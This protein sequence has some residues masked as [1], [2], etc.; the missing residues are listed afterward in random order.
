MDKR[1]CTILLSLANSLVRHSSN[2]SII[3][4]RLV[5][6]KRGLKFGNFIVRGVY[7]LF[8]NESGWE[9]KNERNINGQIF[10][11]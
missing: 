7:G 10:E 3:F 8:C 9:F 5:S 11:I 4:M 6:L 1:C 2:P